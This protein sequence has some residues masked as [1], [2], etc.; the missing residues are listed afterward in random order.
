MAAASRVEV[1]FYPPPADLKRYFTTFYFTRFNLAK[2]EVLEDALQPEWAGLRFFDQPSIEAWIED[3]GRVHDARFIATGPSTRPNHFRIGA[4]RMWGVGLLPL[5]WGQ[6][7]R[8]PAAKHA[9]L[10]IDASRDRAF[11]T[12]MPLLGELF[13][14]GRNEAAQ[15]DRFVSFF[16][17]RLAERLP[18]QQ[19][20][21]AIHAAIVDPEVATVAALVDRIG[22]SQRTVERI[23]HRVF[24]FPPKLLLRRQRFMRSLAQF[25]LDPSLKWIGAIDS[26]YHDQAQFVRDFH[27]FI[28]MS[29][30]E[31]A[32]LPHPVLQTFMQERA[33]VAGAAVQTMD[34][35]AGVSLPED[36][37]ADRAA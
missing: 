20:I 28:G 27:D 6:F 33:R 12:F 1:R 30:R 2:G 14:D 32:N 24:G 13:A 26:H 31:Y 22:A 15:L 16:R 8:Q 18:D 4:C 10:V 35:P 7:V 17:A 25:M 21:L 29:P 3:G 11:R 37:S 23:C 19:R 5:G 36:D 9:N 34:S